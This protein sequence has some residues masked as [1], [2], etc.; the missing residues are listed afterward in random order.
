MNKE[1]NKIAWKK[2]RDSLTNFYN[3]KN[4][5]YKQKKESSNRILEN[6]LAICEKAE[7]LQNSTDWQTAGKEFIKLQEE[8]KNSEFSPSSQSNEIWKRFRT[9]CDTFFKARKVHYKKITDALSFFHSI[10]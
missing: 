1:D 4:E 5:F 10:G 2:L 7:S 6:K 8:W 9:A 3:T